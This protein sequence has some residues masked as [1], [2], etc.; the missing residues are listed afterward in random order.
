M[1]MQDAAWGGHLVRGRH[2]RIRQ[3]IWFIA[4]GKG[5]MARKGQADQAK[6]IQVLRKLPVAT[7]YEA[8]GKFGDM[9]PTIRCFTPGLRLA[10]PAFTVRAMPGDNLVVCRAI[11]E[12]PKGSVL[13]IDAGETDR[14]TIWGGTFTV[15]AKAKGLAG[16]VTNVAVRDLDEMIEEKFPVF[17]RGLSVRGTV[18]SHP[19]WVGIPVCVGDVVV[20]PGDII[21]GDSDGVLVL[22]EDRAEEI[23]EKA[24]AKRRLEV[25]QQSRLRKGEATQ[26]VLLGK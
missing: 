4:E 20:H 14:V 24:L 10:G 13:V 8:S 17:A 6:L 26:H 11:D 23:T 1:P 7:V 2:R 12:A 18:K 22:A 21:L 9:S 15:A 25:A 3:W 19:G 16:V 5:I